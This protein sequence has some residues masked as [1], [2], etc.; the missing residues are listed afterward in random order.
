MLLLKK[1]WTKVLLAAAA[2]VIMNGLIN[3]QLVFMLVTE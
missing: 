1:N 3:P 2:A